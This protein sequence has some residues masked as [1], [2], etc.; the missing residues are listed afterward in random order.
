VTLDFGSIY[1]YVKS[2]SLCSRDLKNT[3][4]WTHLIN[5]GLICF[6]CLIFIINCAPLSLSNAGFALLSHFCKYILFKCFFWSLCTITYFLIRSW[7][8]LKYLTQACILAVNILLRLNSLACIC[9]SFY[10]L[11]SEQI[12]LNLMKPCFL[13]TF[14]WIC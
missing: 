8:V 4:S 2:S 5:L 7:C 14:S 3:I 11:R 10:Y 13:L 12:Y 9:F 6:F 1:L